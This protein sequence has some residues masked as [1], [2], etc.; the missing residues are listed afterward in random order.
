[1]SARMPALNTSRYY[2]WI[3]GLLAA[4]LMLAPSLVRA[5]EPAVSV[6]DGVFITV[7]YPLDDKEVGRVMEVTNLARQNYRNRVQAEAQG[8][9]AA[10]L[11]IVYDFN[12]DG[13]PSGSSMYGSC[14]ELAVFLLGLTDVT[15]IAFVHGEV[16]GHAV[17]PVLACQELVMADEAKLGD[18]IR[19]QQDPVAK[20]QLVFYREVAEKRSRSP[21]LVLKM[22]DKNMEVFAA[23]RPGGVWFVDGNQ[24]NEP[25][26]VIKRAA[27][28]VLPK[29]QTALY[30]ADEAVEYQLCRLKKKSREE[31]ARWYDLPPSSL[32]EDAML[33][34]PRDAWVIEVRGAIT[35]IL[36][37]T[38][39]RRIGRVVGQRSNCI[40]FQLECQGG[41]PEAAGN[42]AEYIRDLKD[43]SGKNPVMTVAYVTEHARDTA[44]FLALGCTQIVMQKN[45]KLGD[46]EAYLLAH[47][48]Y[49]ASMSGMLKNLAEKRYYPP[50]LARGFVEPDLVLWQ[51]KNKGN[52]LE[53]LIVT[54]EQLRGEP[55]KWIAEGNA[56]VKA[57]GQLLTLDAES[58]RRLG[59]TQHVVETK[60][61][62]YAAYR[63]DPQGVRLAEPDW[64]DRFASFLRNFFRSSIM[65]F[66]LVM[67]GITCLV[68]EIK[69]PG[70]TLPGIIA[71]LCFVLF[72][73]AHAELAFLW[74]AVL[75][76]IMGLVL[77]ALEVFVVPGFGVMGISGIIL[78]LG[79]LGLATLERWPQTEGEWMFTITT[80]GRFA[81]GFVGAVVMAVIL[82][83]YLPNIPYANRLVLVPPGETADGA[84]HEPAV[85]SP[86]RAALLGAI[87][88]AATP[89][90]PAGM[91]RFGD[92]YVDV[93]A[94]GSY[95]EPG[96]R[97]QVIEIE[98]N[99]I[100]V[101][102]V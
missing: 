63:L 14:R 89:L 6:S 19:H 48:N 9:K 49:Q 2:L 7:R 71:A 30:T 91:V 59:L 60:G 39:K 55:D 38:L 8:A 53:R 27:G 51:V 12:P 29:G 70:V 11:T 66:L 97:V 74:L 28:P 40:I 101:K 94:E 17:L 83:R 50:L 99:R 13:Q 5:D 36:E 82:A 1:M 45:A 80:I 24:P 93:V 46:F 52:R 87:G 95:V 86:T 77:I 10:S 16:T 3:I 68:L 76:F 42:L 62:L 92:D 79:G 81:L 23:T 31:V 102:E 100:V 61:Q 58:A 15:S 37:E 41:D 21:A 67:V 56:P 84:E 26:L 33:G 57:K 32:R 78:V 96:A 25:G 54:D 35:P 20:D 65:E 72:F 43:N 44:I 18:A 98:A 88:V 90:R 22:L 4:T 85:T 64:L 75:L 47:P 69:M 34:R 73:W